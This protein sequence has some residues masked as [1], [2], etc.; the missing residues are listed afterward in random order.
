MNRY[1]IALG[2]TPLPRPKKKKLAE[3]QSQ[4]IAPSEDP[5][6]LSLLDQIFG[7]QQVRTTVAPSLIPQDQRA[8]IIESY[9]TTADGRARLA[10]SMVNPLRE[11]VNYRSLA[12]RI[13]QV[14]HLVEDNF[15]RYDFNPAGTF[16][17][18]GQGDRALRLL[19]PPQNII[20][21]LFEVASNPQIPLMQIQERR[22]DLIE[23]AQDLAVADIV[24]AEDER[25]LMIL[26]AVA[27]GCDRNISVPQ[28]AF[29]SSRSAQGI[30]RDAFARIEANDLR[31]TNVLLN[32]REY[33]TIRHYSF[34]NPQND[35]AILRDGILANLWGAHMI[36]SR[37]IPAGSVYLTA[38]PASVGRMPIRTDVTVLTADSPM[39]HT[40]GWHILEQIGILCNNPFSIVKV[41]L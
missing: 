34:L 33:A 21:P 17:I 24:R 27:D 12:R 36:V 4:A 28:G 5:N 37:I 16:V 1:D 13:F 38:E 41:S 29:N 30:F 39:D 32:A 22:Y 35:P 7:D 31:V 6:S 15:P 14:D 3:P 18:N 23:R 9:I 11:R 40:I 20:P 26:D 19:T 2:K 25:T 10:A 8:S